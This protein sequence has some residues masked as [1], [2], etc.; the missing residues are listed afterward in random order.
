[1]AR[2]LRIGDDERA[3]I[4]VIERA[5]RDV[6]FHRRLAR[7][8]G[9]EQ[10]LDPL[11]VAIVQT[12]EHL[13]FDG[14]GDTLTLRIARQWGKNECAATVHARHLVRRVGRGGT[15]VRAAPTFRP[16]IVNSIS[17]LQRL[18][19][20]DPLVDMSLFAMRHGYI[21]RY[22]AIDQVPSEV[23]FM[24]SDEQASQ[25]GATADVLLDMDEAHKT[26]VAVYEERFEPFTA[27]TNAP[28]VLWGV[29]GCKDDLLFKEKEKNLASGRSHRVIEIPAKTIAEYRPLYRKHYEG[30]VERLGPSHPVIQT[31]YDLIDIDEFQGAFSAAHRELLFTSDFFRAQSPPPKR[32]G[33]E[34]VVVI[35][36]A[37]EEE[38]QREF[39][40]DV[41]ARSETPDSTVIGVAR[42]DRSRVYMKMPRIDLLDLHILRGE[43][44]VAAPATDGASLQEK[45]LR[46][47]GVWQPKVVL[48]DA[49]GI[50]APL[51]SWLDRVWPRR[52]IQY[53]A[54]RPTT[55]E[56][57][58]D[59]YAWLNVGQLKCF[60][61]DGSAE[62]TT[63]SRELSWVV[64]RHT[65]DTVN[66]V[67]PKGRDRK[68]DTAKAL[69]YLPR[70][71]KSL[72][73]RG[74]WGMNATM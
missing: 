29:A 35:D 22:G 12:I 66:L 18:L 43:K 60:I 30:R 62:Y 24:S 14:T 45:I 10:P 53:S 27:S 26:D 3:A 52:V 33:H 74:A 28:R 15:I 59:T 50:G 47:L 13:M 42:V 73:K 1:M 58:Y 31:Q 21:A 56:D 71:A 40:V 23:M 32:R 6:E 19:R 61:E 8:K 9:Q 67:K 16:Q 72:A 68:I 39:D 7:R 63:L 37:G 38:E 4:A 41:E 64:A 49:R 17:R 57:L 51:A 65:Q 70:V 25:E 54:T 2:D 5:L 34:F 44:M 46:V 69:T 20:N 36:V 55:S 11:Q 48:I